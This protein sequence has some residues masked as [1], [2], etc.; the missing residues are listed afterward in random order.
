MTDTTGSPADSITKRLDA[1]IRL[2]ME[3]QNRNGKLKRSEQLRILNSVGLSSA[4]MA[5]ILNQSSKD[6]ASAMGK[7]RGKHAKG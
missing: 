3:E 1:I 7:L 2:L 6:V 5:R 4:E